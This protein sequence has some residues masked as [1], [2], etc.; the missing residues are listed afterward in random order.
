MEPYWSYEDV[1]IYFFVLV[2]LGAV[3]RIAVR[4]HWL[5]PAQ[6]VTPSLALQTSVIAFLG[7]ALYLILKW[8]H[9]RPTQEPLLRCESRPSEHH[10]S[11]VTLCHTRS[12]AIS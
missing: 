11:I 4:A 7:I 2:F 8:R 12:W 6:L 9:R 5:S 3:V 10:V 1:G